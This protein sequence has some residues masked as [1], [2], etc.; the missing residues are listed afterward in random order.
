MSVGDKVSVE[1]GGLRFDVLRREFEED[2]DGGTS[3]EVYG[4]VEG[5]PTQVLRFDCFRKAPHYHMP[6]SA[7]GQLELDPRQVGD[8]LDWAL[9]QTR[10]H[11]PEMLRKAGFPELSEQVDAAALRRDWE[12]VKRAVET[13]PL[14]SRTVTF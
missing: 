13:A 3:I 5:K 6:P 4:D 14:P 12:R 11:L 8:P 7:P 9:A 2:A 10:E 1:I